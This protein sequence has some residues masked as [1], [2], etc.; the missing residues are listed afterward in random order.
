MSRQFVSFSEVKQ[1][2]SCEDVMRACDVPMGDY[3]IRHGTLRGPCPIH[4]DPSA[5][6]RNKA[7]FV[8]DSKKGVSL[9]RC[10]GDCDSGGDCI[11]LAKALTG[12]EDTQI[13]RW[14]A[15]H[16][17]HRLNV[18]TA[19]G[20][21]KAK[22][23]K[24]ENPSPG[25]DEPKE[26]PAKRKLTP[27]R[28][29]YQNLNPQHPYLLEER[30]LK[31]E[32]IERYGIG[33]CS[34]GM[35]VGRITIPI[36]LPD[37]DEGQNPVAY[38]GRQVTDDDQ[39]PRYLFPE[40]FPRNDVVYGLREA[41]RDSEEGQPLVIVEGPFKVFDLH[42]KLGLTNVVATFGSSLGDGQAQALIAT[43]RPLALLWDG[44]AHAKIK[45]A[46][47]RLIRHAFVRVVWLDEGVEP[48]DLTVEEL[49]ALLSF[50]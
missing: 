33:Y 26:K 8:V 38:V 42:T 43:G 45:V 22:P 10:F 12:L 23:V 1:V 14:L 27:L 5:K 46:A 28:F 11:T 13:T 16:F 15:D 47:A 24:A 2:I 6:Y 40:G 35:M 19:N 49:K 7:Q 17:G 34:K 25:E 36:Y 21:R 41:L 30:G 4:G 50:L 48:D 9:W 31:P 3:V 18:E 44:D 39:Y 29:A 37:Q 32:T 20:N